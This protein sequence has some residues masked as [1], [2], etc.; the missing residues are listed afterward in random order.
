V[1][2]DGKTDIVAAYQYSDGT[3]RLHVFLNGNSYQGPTGWFQSG[4]FPMSNVAGR[5]AGGD[6]DGNGKGDIVM[7]Y[8]NGPGVNIYRFFSSGSAFSYNMTSIASGYDMDQVGSRLATGDI[9][10][11][12][13]ADS[14]VAYQYPDGTMRLHVFLDGSWYQGASG[15]FQ[16]GSFNL[17]NVGGRFTMGAW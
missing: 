2:G 1:N 6:F 4:N 3:M 8:D 12:G 7:F 11:D 10:G 14:V 13:K 9:N 15:W 17:S 5:M 16:S